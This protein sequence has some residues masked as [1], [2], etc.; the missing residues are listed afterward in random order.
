M[1]ACVNMSTSKR[2]HRV[3]P[4]VHIH[5]T[6]IRKYIEHQIL[7]VIKENEYLDVSK[8]SGLHQESLL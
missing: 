2:K 6:H 8:K 5:V 3:Q 1:C 7:Q 4:E